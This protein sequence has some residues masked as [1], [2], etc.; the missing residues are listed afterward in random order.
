MNNF[1]K[2]IGY[3]GNLEPLLSKISEDFKIGE[4]LSHSIVTMGY[5]DFNLILKTNKGNFFVKIFA[6][7][8]NEKECYRYINVIESILKAGISHPLLYKSSQGYLYQIKMDKTIIRLCIMEYI[9]GKTFYEL[10][11]DPTNGE[12]RFIVKQ[13]ALINK[14]KIKPDFVYDNWA[15]TNF[16]E[17]YDK[18]AKYLDKENKKLISPLAQTFKSLSIKTLPHCLAHGDITK[19]N[20]MKDKNGRI[21]IIDFAVSNYY[22]RIQEL[23]VLICDLLSK[24]NYKKVLDEY[25]KYIKLTSDEIKKLP[26]YVKLA[27]AMHVLCGTYEK[28]VNKNNSAENEYFIKIGR[29]GLRSFSNS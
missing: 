9:D 28:V 15:I 23:A 21:Y 8:R 17:Q 14:V 22:P 4:Y 1:Q 25:Q 11:K 18:K 5:E 26:L 2:R 3:D 10:K 27:H 29:A 19:T 13:A 7:F 16:L 6:K 12:I 20:T 24:N